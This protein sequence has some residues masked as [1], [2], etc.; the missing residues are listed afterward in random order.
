MEKDESIANPETRIV[1]ACVPDA[2]AEEDRPAHRALIT[3][4]FR[5]QLLE[6]VWLPNGGAYRFG[7]E[8][9]QDVAGFVENERR[10][11]PFLAFSV[12]I[13][14]EAGPLWLRLVGPPGTR[15]FLETELP[16]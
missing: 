5:K 14:A 16:A 9:F 13:T 3:R 11:C 6:R 15:Q 10:C 1:L 4:L 12:E 8:D 2:I 7:A